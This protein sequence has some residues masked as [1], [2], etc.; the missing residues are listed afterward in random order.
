MADPDQVPAVGNNLNG[1]VYR[2]R[3]RL[4]GQVHPAF[5]STGECPSAYVMHLGPPLTTETHP[6]DPEMECRKVFLSL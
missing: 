6:D 5:V 3:T 4:T 2:Y 1:Q